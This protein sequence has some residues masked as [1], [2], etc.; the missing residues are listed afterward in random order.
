[1]SAGCAELAIANT[2]EARHLD[3]VETFQRQNIVGYEL[4]S[5]RY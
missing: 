1:M 2:L 3:Y 5:T 4:Y